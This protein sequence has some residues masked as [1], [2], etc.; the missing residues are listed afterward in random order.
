MNSATNFNFQGNLSYRFSPLVKIKY[1]AVYD[2]SEYQTYSNAY[3]YNPD[4]RGTYYGNGLI[5]SLI[6]RIRLMTMYFTHYNFLTV[7]TIMSTIFLRILIIQVICQVNIREQ[8]GNTFYLTGGTD[9]Y[10]EFR[11]TTTLGLKG[12]VV[13]QL[14]NVHEVKAGFEYRQHKLNFEGY[15]VQFG[16]QNPDGSF[17]ANLLANDLLYDTTL[18][19]L[20]DS[21]PIS[22]FILNTNINHCSLLYILQDK[23]ELASTFILNAGLRYELFDPAAQYNPEISQ[24]LIDSLAGNITAYNTDAEIKHTLSPRISISY[25]ITDQG[26]IRFSYGHF[27]QIGSLASL[28]TNPNY[29]V[30]NVGE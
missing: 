11:K 4:G 12:D 16:K 29:Y 21:Q 14:F 2:K 1:E 18:I 24:N 10:R 8:L 25:P 6:S 26:I 15:S 19:L 27:Y 17:N 22:H 23:V 5:Q 13:A 28:Y 20:E 9:N 3:K 30:T 7:T